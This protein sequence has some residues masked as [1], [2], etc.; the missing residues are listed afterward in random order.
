M[1][2][3]FLCCSSSLLSGEIEECCD[4]PHTQPFCTI[5]DTYYPLL[6]CGLDLWIHADALFLRPSED[7]I[8]LTNRKTN[9]FR[10]NNVSLEPA[11]HT[12]FR[13]DFGSR[14][15]FGHTFDDRL[16]D[17]VLDWT[18]YNSDTTKKSSTRGEISEGMFPIWSLSDDIIP[19]DWVAFA[20]MHWSLNLNLIDL[21]FGRAFHW[22]C[23][24]LRPYAGLRTFWIDQDF[25][26]FYGGGIFANGPDLYAMTNNA[27][28]DSIHMENDYWGLGP[29]LGISPQLN[30]GKGFRLYGNAAGSFEGGYYHLV[31]NE[32]YLM[33]TRFNLRSHPVRFRWI[34]DAEGGLLWE[35]FIVKEQFALTFKLG[36]QYFIF[37]DQFALQKD[38]FGLVPEDNDLSLNGG[39]FS[40]RFDF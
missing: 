17:V 21:E 25:N 8:V 34:L 31:Q 14:I 16:W 22:G 15:G 23:F 2:L 38:Q 6:R 4:E 18:F 12:Q 27:G 29:R 9:L 35:T 39:A 10:V 30:L 33:H 20:K 36:W 40:A 26:V 5:L 1:I 32:V 3:L 11:L 24:F 7:P 28:Y 19:Y 37:F 13:W